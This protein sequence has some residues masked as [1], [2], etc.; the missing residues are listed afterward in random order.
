[1]KKVFESINKAYGICGKRGLISIKR[2]SQTRFQVRRFSDDGE[3]FIENI[4]EPEAE[5]TEAVIEYLPESEGAAIITDE[6][7]GT[8][9]VI[10][11]VDGGSTELVLDDV[12]AD[13][14]EEEEIVESC[15]DVEIPE[16]V[17]NS[18][19]QDIINAFKAL[20]KR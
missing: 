16:V 4:E 7:A 18:G 15:G 8:D 9:E 6:D 20:S 10:V 12:V 14:F 11:G 1:M 5:G 2:F 3:E 17:M 13:G 19:N